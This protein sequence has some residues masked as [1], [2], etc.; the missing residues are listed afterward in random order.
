MVNQ[1]AKRELTKNERRNQ[2]SQIRHKKR[3][4]YM[5]NKRGL[6][7]APF[8]I[9]LVPLNS[10]I[11]T[12]PILSLFKNADSDAVVAYSPESQLHIG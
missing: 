1:R 2:A 7:D 12:S 9:A 11:K 4:E 10:N 5:Q 3:E 6:T 8:L